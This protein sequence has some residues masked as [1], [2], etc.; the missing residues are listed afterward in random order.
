MRK[1]RIL[2][3]N[4]FSELATGYA[5]Y[6]KEI[7][8][9]LHNS[10][11][12]IVG[13]F[14]SY[15]ENRDPKASNIPWVLYPNNPY[16]EELKQFE[17]NPVNQFGS[18]R[19][20][21]VLLDF[22]PDLVFSIRD[23]WMDDFISNSP[24]RNYYHWAWMPT[25][26]SAP[27]NDAWFE[28]Y[29]DC[30]GIFGYTDWGLEVLKK[31]S[32]NKLNLLEAI[33]PGTEDFFQP[34]KDKAKHR[35]NMG[36]DENLFIVGSVM[37]N[38]KRKLYP[39]LI[40]SFAN[41][42]QK[43]KESGN[44]DLYK[45]SYLYLHTTYPDN[46]WDIPYLLKEHGVVGKTLVTYIC[47]N[48]QL[49]YPSFFQDGL[50]GC[51]RCG[52]LS[53]TM[54][55][56]SRAVPREFLAAVT[57]LFD[58]YVQYSIAEGFGLPVMEA[59]HCGI[60]LI[61]SNYSGLEDF[62]S[63]CQAIPISI[64]RFYKEA[65]TEAYR[66]YPNNEELTE[67]LYQ[68]AILPEPLRRKKG[69]TALKGAKEHFTWDKTYKKLEKHF[70]NILQKPKRK[71]W[72]A[73]PDIRIPKDDR[74]INIPHED[75]LK[76]MFTNVLCEPEKIGSYM[77][78]KLNRFLT[79]GARLETKGGLVFNDSS[80]LASQGKW[81]SYNQKKCSEELL[82]IREEKNIHEQIRCGMIKYIAPRFIQESFNRHLLRD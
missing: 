79:Y 48:C 74:P 25:V 76:Y 40:E 60:P 12:Y 70:D 31:Q 78:L 23:P 46:G 68:L 13:E 17:S 72:N 35:S 22:K 53:A 7:L 4:E 49:C 36:L 63:K 18:W 16:P 52:K 14:A 64:Q 34:V 47:N 80:V 62:V 5:V 1:P 29:Q 27:Q 82:R 51:V 11:K 57:N 8:K 6:G 3:C 32:N 20:S 56:T 67:K 75:F 9:R 81:N 61:V 55:S 37:R 66:A 19:F 10:G 45:R 59:A 15:C 71:E 41:Y 58:V 38:Q 69:L 28:L 54:P 43:C 42:L 24:L 77:Y 30:D 33:P 39:D 21:D 65:E 50:T 2:F 26:D 73:K 44:L